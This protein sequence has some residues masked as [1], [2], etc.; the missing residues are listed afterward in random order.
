MGICENQYEFI[1]TYAL[2]YVNNSMKM[3]ELG[4]QVLNPILGN[5][6]NCKTGKELYQSTGFDHTSFDL[7]GNNGALKIDITQEN[8]KYTNIF[9]IITDHGTIEHIPNQ[10]LTFRNLHNWGNINCVYAHCI[11]LDSDEHRKYIGYGFPPH[12]DYEYSTEFWRELC[13]LCNYNLIISTGN[14][15]HNP[16]VNFPINYYSSSVYI[17]TLESTFPSE[18]EFNDFLN[19][20]ITNTKYKLD[21]IKLSTN[22]WKNELPNDVKNKYKL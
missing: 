13:K 14:T 9:N 6:I 12:G 21:N 18:S 22:N 4:D 8:N 2:P 17:K 7:N 11:P 20:Y 15:V 3:L 5:P 10:Y 19:K 1:K 16:A